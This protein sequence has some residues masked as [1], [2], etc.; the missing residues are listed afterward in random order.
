MSF[1]FYNSK[2]TDLVS[3]D[4]GPNSVKV[5]TSGGV[6]MFEFRILRDRPEKGTEFIAMSVLKTT[7]ATTTTTT[8]KSPKLI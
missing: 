8:T 1:T 2:C 3:N 5:S 7:T 4:F 6:V